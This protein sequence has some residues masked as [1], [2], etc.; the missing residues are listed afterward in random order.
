MLWFGY[1]TSTIYSK[2]KALGK[3]LSH[4]T[5]RNSSP[6]QCQ[7]LQYDQISYN[8]RVKKRLCIESMWWVSPILFNVSTNNY[9]IYG[10][11]EHSINAQNKVSN[12]LELHIQ[13]STVCL[14]SFDMVSFKGVDYELENTFFIFGMDHVNLLF[15]WNFSKYESVFSTGCFTFI[16]LLNF[17][18]L[19]LIFQDY[20]VMHRLQKIVGFLWKM[21]DDIK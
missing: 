18:S 6:H 1:T 5:N 10:S 21:Y 17:G 8:T 20:Y 11:E 15:W 3:W 2:Q 19:T 16:L 7:S 13:P 14:E 12:I 4:T 9:N